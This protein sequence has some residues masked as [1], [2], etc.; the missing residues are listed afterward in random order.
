MHVSVCVCLRLC[1][2]VCV[3]VCMCV[4]V[5]GADTEAMAAVLALDGRPSLPVPAAQE[6]A[7]HG[8]H[9]IVHLIAATSVAVRACRLR[10][11]E[12]C[13][14]PYATDAGRPSCPSCWPSGCSSRWPRR[15]WPRWSSAVSGAVS[16]RVSI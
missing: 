12:R 4:H 16:V 9:T 13:H 8:V 11:A 15:I 3:C 2:C 10:A 5:V 14:V 6:A 7:A 1:A